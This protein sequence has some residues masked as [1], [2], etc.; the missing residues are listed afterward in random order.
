ML[1]QQNKC[2]RTNLRH[3]DGCSLVADAGQGLEVLKGVGHL[4]VETLADLKA[5]MDVYT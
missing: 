2:N 1:V 3:H 5:C 4:P